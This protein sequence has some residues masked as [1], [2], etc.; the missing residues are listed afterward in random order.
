MKKVL[1][2]LF[3]LLTSCPIYAQRAIYYGYDAS[4][5]RISRELRSQP[6][7]G[8]KKMGDNDEV[9]INGN[10]IRIKLNGKDGNLEIHID[11]WTENDAAAASVYS[12][13][14]KVLMSTTANSPT[15]CSV[16]A[17]LEFAPWILYFL[18]RNSFKSQ[19]NIT[20]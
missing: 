6:A 3:V 4:G 8:K 17:D 12:L 7:K 9:W 19:G 20:S 15:L 2:L 5:N 16:E 11:N 13:D 18:F 10:Q 1:V 14:G